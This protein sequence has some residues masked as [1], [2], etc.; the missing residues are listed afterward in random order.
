MYKLIPKHGKKNNLAK[1]FESVNLC[2]LMQWIREE[3]IDISQTITMKTLLDS[4][5]LRRI[6][7]GVK[8]LAGHL[9]GN[10][11]AAA[12]LPPLHFQVS[13]SSL[14]AQALIEAAGG[15]VSYVFFN[16]VTLRAHLKPEKFPIPPRSNGVP[17]PVWR[18]HYGFDMEGKKVLQTPLPIKDRM[19]NE[20]GT[21]GLGEE[22]SLVTSRRQAAKAKA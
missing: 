1:P 16:R 2:K 13:D 7:Y 11:S 4:G 21:K 20:K 22:G 3:R 6:P 8:I 12:M 10:P 17:P 9:K 15:S 18:E 5:L 19:A 14:S